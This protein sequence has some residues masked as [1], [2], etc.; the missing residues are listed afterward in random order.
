[1]ASPTPSDCGTFTTSSSSD[2]EMDSAYHGTRCDLCSS[3]VCLPRM[4]SC[5][6]TFCQ[7][8]ME[9]ALHETGAAHCPLCPLDIYLGGHDVSELNQPARRDVFSGWSGASDVV[10]CTGCK[11]KDATASAICF[12]CGNFLCGN[13]VMAHQ[14]M[15]RF[16]GHRVMSLGHLQGDTDKGSMSDKP[17]MCLQHS[18]KV[19]DHFCSTCAK[20]VCSDCILEHNEGHACKP[21]TDVADDHIDSLRHLLANAK[22][23]IDHLRALTKRAAHNS[24]ALVSQHRNSTSGIN[25]TFAFYS[26]MLDRRRTEAMIELH[27]TFNTKQVAISTQAQQIQNTTHTLSQGVQYIDK[28]LTHSSVTATLLMKRYLDEHFQN[29]FSYLP[30]LQNGQ[31]SEINFV[32]DY[33][34]I[35][36]D[37]QANFGFVRQGCEMLQMTAQKF[38]SAGRV[39]NIY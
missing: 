34:T 32:S 30:S 8:C 13:C 26:S 12:D 24:S 7:P 35:Q 5:H 17:D 31:H 39:N 33:Q 9:R 2:Y 38:Q 4:L 21:L 16:K 11:I 1:M 37:L 25:A 14:F 28:V 22:H 10:H 23:K 18:N 29:L 20:P 27:Q 15:N 6:H 36:T 19:L 3:S